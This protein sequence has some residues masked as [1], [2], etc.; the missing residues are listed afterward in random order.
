VARGERVISVQNPHPKKILLV[1][2]P[3]CTRV[4]DRLVQAGCHVTK[5]A[6]G[7][8]ALDGVKHDVIDAVILISTG[9]EMDVTETALN[10]RDVDP[11][12]EIIIIADR[13]STEETAPETNTITY[14]IPKTKVF[15]ASQLDHYLKSAEWN[16]KSAVRSAL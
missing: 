16:A 4:E 13:E 3:L 15:T 1:C 2:S 5:V 9:S 7:A 10:L 11:S 6:Q 8:A 12:V 14:A